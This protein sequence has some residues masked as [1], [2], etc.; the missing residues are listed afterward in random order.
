MGLF[1]NVRGPRKYN[2]QPVFFDPRK[3][4]L[5]ER[6]S[7]IK[8]EIGM[9]PDEEYKANLKGAFT[10]QSSHV[11]RRLE[12]EEKSDATRN[13]KIAIVLAVLVMAF[14]YFYIR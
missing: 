11:R 8:K 2:H 12:N 6:V 7:K 3:D 1:F 13:I 14:Y 10:N 5:H 4:A 9:L